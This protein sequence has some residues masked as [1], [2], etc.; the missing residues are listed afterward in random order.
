MTSADRDSVA[1]IAIVADNDEVPADRF[2]NVQTALRNAGL[3]T[4]GAPSTIV[5]GPPAVGV[6]MMPVPG[7]QGALESLLF[8]ATAGAQA[9]LGAHFGHRDHS[10]RSIVIA[11][12]GGS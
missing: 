3:L 10:D 11:E 4:P 7:V 6:F 8:D 12:I 1:R 2:L 9:V 5:L